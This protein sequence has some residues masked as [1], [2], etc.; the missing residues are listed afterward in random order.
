VDTLILMHANSAF[1]FSDVGNPVHD[2]LEHAEPDIAGDH[3][4]DATMD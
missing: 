3:I 4:D 2:S 1:I